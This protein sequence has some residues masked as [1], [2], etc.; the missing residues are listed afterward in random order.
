MPQPKMR[1]DRTRSRVRTV[2]VYPVAKAAFDHSLVPVRSCVIERFAPNRRKWESTQGGRGL[3]YSR[4]RIPSN[5]T[6]RAKVGKAIEFEL[7]A[8][9]LATQGDANSIATA[10]IGA[11]HK[12]TGASV[13]LPSTASALAWMV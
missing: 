2:R 6:T 8:G 13:S 7:L 4:N 1:T 10:F 12:T 3:R 5:P 9:D 11:L